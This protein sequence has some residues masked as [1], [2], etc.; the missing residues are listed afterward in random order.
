MYHGSGD[1]GT[2]DT[3]MT[4]FFSFFLYGCLIYEKEMEIIYELK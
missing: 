1:R 3:I 2:D 4:I